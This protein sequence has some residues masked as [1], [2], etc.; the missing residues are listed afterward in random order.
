MNISA[1][2]GIAM[3]P[4]DGSDADTLLK[5]ADIAL[6]RAKASGRRVY[7]FFEREM[8]AVLQERHRLELDLRAALDNSEFELFYQPLVDLTSGQISGFEALTRWH[9]PTRGLVDAREFILLTE[10]MGLIAPLGQWALRRHAG[11]RRPGPAT[12]ACRSICPPLSSSITIC[13]AA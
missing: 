9:H 10:E 7:R 11:R 4:A 1:S 12:C 2:I 3:I 5:N 6:Y 8:D 13:W